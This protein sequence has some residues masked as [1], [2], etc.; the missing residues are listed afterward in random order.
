LIIFV[1]HKTRIT[2]TRITAYKR[3]VYCAI[4]AQWQRKPFLFGFWLVCRQS[5]KLVNVHSS[6]L[7]QKRN[8]FAKICDVQAKHTVLHYNYLEA[9]VITA[10]SERT[11]FFRDISWLSHL[12]WLHAT[13][14][15]N[16]CALVYSACLDHF[17]RGVHGRIIKW[18]N[19]SK[20]AKKCRIN[21]RCNKCF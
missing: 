10:W 7:V 15:L 14:N 16:I 2:K 5:S 6:S 20:V 17:H 3:L 21:H 13:D 18:S 12:L 11:K 9:N 1:Y 19:G 8:L 4:W